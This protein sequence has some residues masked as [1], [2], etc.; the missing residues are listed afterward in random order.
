MLELVQRQLFIFLVEVLGGNKAGHETV[1]VCV[2]EIVVI[3]VIRSDVTGIAK[4]L[5]PIL[6]RKSLKAA[7]SSSRDCA[8]PKPPGWP[9]C[10][11][12]CSASSGANAEG[13]PS[14]LPVLPTLE[15][16]NGNEGS[17]DKIARPLLTNCAVTTIHSTTRLDA[18]T[19]TTPTTTLTTNVVAKLNLTVEG[20][21]LY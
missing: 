18:T 1:D 2:H 5:G 11:A 16:E 6:L 15:I 3:G 9:A 13:Q 21:F 10:T 20:L 14:W 12:C 4:V 8:W 17:A 19:H 7:A